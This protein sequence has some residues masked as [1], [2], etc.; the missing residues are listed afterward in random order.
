M[1]FNLLNRLLNKIAYLSPCGYTLQPW[2]HSMRGVKMGRNVW[3][4]QYVYIDE[5][6]PE[7]VTIR[8]NVTVGLRSSIFTHFYWG[9]RRPSY[10][11]REV[12]IEKDVF[13]G[14]HCLILPGVCVGEGSVI[15]GGS[16]LTK[17]V[18]PLTFW[19]PPDC[20]PIAKVTVPLT[21]DHDYVQFA[22]GLRPLRKQRPAP[23]DRMP[24][25]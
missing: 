6:H 8:D 13:I 22:Q 14:P 4:S 1:R 17:S 5:L 7:G 23:G 24:L 20:G 16:V 3:I 11:S 15:K 25:L 12:V 10:S 9:S 21:K 18:P 2:L 19:G